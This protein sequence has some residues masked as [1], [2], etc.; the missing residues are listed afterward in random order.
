MWSLVVTRERVAVHVHVQLAHLLQI[1]AYQ[2]LQTPPSFGQT[3]LAQKD[4]SRTTAPL[5]RMCSL[6]MD[7]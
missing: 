5:F 1:F 2:F 7:S 4:L 6:L 3:L